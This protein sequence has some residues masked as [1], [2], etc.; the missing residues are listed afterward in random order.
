MSSEIR[1]NIGADL[2]GGDRSAEE[3]PLGLIAV[4]LVEKGGLRR[5]F[6][7]LD[8]HPHVQLASERDDRFHDRLNIA[9]GAVEA[10]HEAAV[11]LDLVERETP[12]IA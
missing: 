5:G 3:E 11:D 7:T 4:G 9:A 8:R 2:G 12:Q 10:L 1:E 6:D